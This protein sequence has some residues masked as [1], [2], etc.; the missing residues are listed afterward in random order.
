MG[1]RTPT[2]LGA[3]ASLLCGALPSLLSACGDDGLSRVNPRIEVDP[4]ALDFGA[5]IVDRDNLQ[6]I[7]VFNRG[8]VPLEIRGAT[9]EGLG[10]AVKEAPEVVRAYGEQPLLLA[11][12][13][14]RAH[15]VYRAELVLTSNDPER[16]ELRVPL[17]GVGG[18]R[19]VVVRPEVVDFGVVNEGAA[20]RRSVEIGNVGGDP[21]TVQVVFT[22][23]SVDLGPIPGSFT[24]TGTPGER[25]RRFV[26]EA[27]TST[28]VELVYSPVDLGADFGLLVVHSNDEERPRIEV[29]VRGMA[30]LAPRA[31]AFT[32][33]KV[34]GQVGCDEQRRQKTTSAGL[35]R[36]LGLDGRESWDPEG[37]PIESYRWV[38]ERR[39]EGSRAAVY[40]SS[41]DI[42]ARR[43]STGDIEV[44]RVGTFSLRLIVRDDRGLESKDDAEARVEIRPKDLE[45]R[46][47]W[48]V[49]TDVDVHLVRPGGAVGDYGSGRVRTST[50]SDCSA[51]NREP[52]WGDLTSADDDPRLDKDDV[53]GTGPEI[54]S[55]DHPESGGAYRLYAHYCDSRRVNV[56]V[57]V[58]AEVWVR[59]VL[60]DTVPLMNGFRMLPGQLWEAARIVWDEGQN[61]ALVEPLPD[62]QAVHRPELCILP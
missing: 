45:V 55:L 17:A 58:T 38:L 50:G 60:V 27:E 10:F 61:T 5:G 56:N 44:D 46:L 15:E 24:P 35:R 29:P 39:P 11:F 26:L 42:G 31:V 20:P 4:E 21:L 3:C 47:R 9:V 34:A 33:E 12:H 2:M 43:R 23:T 37:G 51:F 16:P 57:Y 22:S 6:A 14:L 52:N 8:G 28:V 30:N 18:V 40:H 32:C 13:P 59:G 41:E 25:E 48:D 62:G 36:L 54:I 19:S 49:G 1:N 53:T 7:R